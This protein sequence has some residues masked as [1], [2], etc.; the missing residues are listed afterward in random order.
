[1]AIVKRKSDGSIDKRSI[2][3]TSD[4]TLDKRSKEYK[5]FVRKIWQRPELQK[6]KNINFNKSIKLWN[7]NILVTKR[8]WSIPAG[9]T[10]AAIED[11][12]CRIYECPI[13]YAEVGLLTS[14]SGKGR[15]QG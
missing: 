8:V 5:L 14:L 6:K 10:I 9:S 12:G 1:M 4:G 13:D 3:H 11:P 2:P 15:R 7:G